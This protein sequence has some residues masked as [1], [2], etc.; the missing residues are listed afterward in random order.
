M[1]NGSP[2]ASAQCQ[3]VVDSHVDVADAGRHIERAR[4]E[5]RHD[6]KVLGAVLDYDQATGE[7][8]W[9][10]R[11][12]DYFRGGFAGDWDHPGRPPNFPCGLC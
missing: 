1:T 10:R 9:Q 5:D 11:I 3:R 4:P 12:N 2:L 8:V 6:P 7:R